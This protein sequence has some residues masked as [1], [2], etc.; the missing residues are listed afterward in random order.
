MDSQQQSVFNYSQQMD[1]SNAAQST[2]T[3][4]PTVTGVTTTPVADA[5]DHFIVS[6]VLGVKI[7]ITEKSIAALLNMEKAGGRRI[8]NINPRAKYIAHEI[9]PTIFKL[10]TEGNPSKNKELHQNLRVWLKIILGTIHHRPTSNSSDYINTY[11]KCIMYC[12]HKGLKL[13]LPALLFKYLRDSV[14]ETRNN[15]KPKTY[16]P[17]G[18][19]LSDV[20]IENGLVDHLEKHKL[21]EDM[22]IETGRPLNSR[23]LKSMGIL[24]KIQV[25][26]TLD[27][28]WEALKD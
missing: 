2:S 24:K 25:K 11:Q 8:Y 22:A 1:S 17:L 16:I 9:N 13:C 3:S 26:P 4:T 20:L 14:R 5:D 18:R 6:Y 12:I 21:M 10:N 28:S 15:M 27:T 23:S 7:V 19:L